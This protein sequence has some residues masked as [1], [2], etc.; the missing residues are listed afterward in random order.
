MKQEIHTSCIKLQN[1]INNCLPVDNS[2]LG[3][4]LG[5][6]LY[7]YSLYKAFGKKEDAEMAVANLE[8]TVAAIDTDKPQLYGTS[9][10][11]GS[12]GL[13][14][15]INLLNNNGLIE[16]E[17]NELATMDQLLF[18]TAMN[19]INETDAVDY[20]HGAMGIVYYFIQRLPNKKIAGYLSKLIT[21]FCKKAI[22]EPE[23]LWFKN[24]VLEVKE[25]DEINFSLSHGLSGFLLI[26]IEAAEKGIDVPEIKEIVEKGMEFILFYKKDIDFLK[27]DFTFFPSTI[28]A[29]DKSQRFYTKR[30][31]WCYGDTNV[32]LLMI[33][34]GKFLNYPG[35]I[36]FGNVVGTAGIMRKKMD[37][38]AATESHLC[39]GTAG[40]AQFYKKLYTL[41]K[42]EAYQK[43]WHH[44]IRETVKLLPAE[45]EKGTYAG[46]EC[47]LLEGLAGVNLALLSFLSEEELDWSSTLLI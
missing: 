45:L 21:S 35:W 29:L 27:E 26:L 42:I 17:M 5:M 47:D 38:I 32:V 6:V 11:S 24:Y 39:H 4:R 40:L 12:A 7:Y 22:L 16:F 23:G 10:A 43:A 2:L 8:I 19:Q 20:L 13:G 31:A 46:K 1:I 37:Q 28:N 3:G 18:E 36:K 30:L 14:Y 25:K 41:T 15:I 33:R 34:A 9:F 44:W